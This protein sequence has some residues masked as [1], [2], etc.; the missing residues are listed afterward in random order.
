L[1]A[2][3]VAHQDESSDR[4][5]SL[6][7]FWKKSV[8]AVVAIVVDMRPSRNPERC[9]RCCVKFWRQLRKFADKKM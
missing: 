9:E 2:A 8:G 6:D 7:R 3:V 1:A 4:L 5:T